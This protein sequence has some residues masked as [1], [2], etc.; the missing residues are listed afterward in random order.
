MQT[1]Q[2]GLFTANIAEVEISYKNKVRPADRPK[3]DNSNDCAD[4]FRR[5]WTDTLEHHESFYSLM[6]DRANKVLGVYRVSEGGTTGTIADPKM[7]FQAA[8]KCNAAALIL[9]H[10]HPSGNL[11]PSVSDVKLTEKMKAAGVLLDI[12]VLDH[13]ILGIDDKYYS[14]ADNGNVF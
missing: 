1:F 9:A 8:L 4:I 14:F 12:P 5:I 3:L 13:V 2:I 7:I 6:L 10:N 11:I